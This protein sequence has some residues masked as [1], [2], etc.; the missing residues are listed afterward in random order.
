M[1][2]IIVIDDHILLRDMIVDTLNN[3]KDF[4]VVGVSNDAKDAPELCAKSNPDVLLMD[5]CTANNSNGI[6]FAK[7][8][9]KNHP[10]IKIIIMTGILD[11]S[12]INEAKQIGIESFIYKN[13]SKDSLVSTIKNTAN[14]YSIYP[15]SNRKENTSDSILSELTDKEMQILKL[16][17]RLLDKDAVA[18]ALSISPRTLKSHIHS[19]Y[20]KT[21]FNNLAKL[22]IYCVSNG[23]IVSNLD[24][25]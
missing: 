17:C 25:P 11:V 12:F 18:E 23:F 7:I 20:D 14:G 24:E 3:E 19:I 6:A 4:N 9:K 5:I 2:K 13:I 21:G 15:N 8:V 1:L 22:A 10:N 16:Y